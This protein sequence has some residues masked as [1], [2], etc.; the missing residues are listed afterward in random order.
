MTIGLELSWGRA[1]HRYHALHIYFLAFVFFLCIFIHH[2]YKKLQKDKKT[3]N[4][5]STPYICVVEMFVLS[6]LR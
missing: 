2:A 4:I 6:L 3:K 1:P 5:Y